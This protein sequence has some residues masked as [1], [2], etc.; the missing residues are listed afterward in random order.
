MRRVWEHKNR[1]IDGFTSKYNVTM[2]VYYEHFE[3]PSAAI[4][5][6]KRMKG[7]HRKWKLKLIE[8]VNPAWDELYDAEKG[9]RS[10]R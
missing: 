9:I 10:I 8:G 7:W 3:H 2:L 1:I 6:E 4:T 5:R